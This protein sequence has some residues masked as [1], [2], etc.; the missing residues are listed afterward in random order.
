[1]LG[2]HCAAQFGKE[3][4]GP[5]QHCFLRLHFLA[6]ALAGFHG[7]GDKVLC[8]LPQSWL[9]HGYGSEAKTSEGRGRILLQWELTR[10]SR[11]KQTGSGTQ[12]TAFSIHLLIST[13]SRF[14][15]KLKMFPK[16]LNFYCKDLLQRMW[17]LPLF[18]IAI[19]S[20]DSVCHF[21]P[22]GQRGRRHLQGCWCTL[23][24]FSVLVVLLVKSRWLCCLRSRY[25]L[26]VPSERIFVLFCRSGSMC[27]CCIVLFYLTRQ[28][29][30]GS[31]LWGL[32][33]TSFCITKGKYQSTFIHQHPQV[34]HE[35]LESVTF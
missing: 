31:M 27:N 28:C 3:E 5:R 35:F 34:H 32:H 11:R 33:F 14:Y 1:M 22:G 29:L 12:R 9:G 7:T 21:P 23:N 15:L 6:T 30:K 20:G 10:N 4:Q 24:T 17:E 8:L 25:N 19:S 26:F 13:S 2:P 16:I 18:S